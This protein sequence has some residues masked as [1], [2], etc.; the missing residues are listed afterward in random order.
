M[1]NA[2]YTCPTN[3]IPLNPPSST[4]I[5]VRPTPPPPKDHLLWSICN[6]LY[7]NFCCLGFLALI[8]SV[9]TRDQNV[10]GNVKAAHLYSHK[11]K[12][13]NILASG[14]NV[15]IPLLIIVLIVTG[16]VHLSNVKGS[17]D[18]FGSNH[19]GIAGYYAMQALKQDMIG[20]SYTNTSPLVV[21]TRA[22]DCTLGTNPISV[23][24]P[25]ND[26]DSFVLD[27]ATS[28]VALGKVELHH[29]SGDT[30]PEGWGCDSHGKLS[31]DPGK[32]LSGGGLLPI[33][34]CE[35]TG[36]YK[37]YGLGMMV[38][39]FCGILAGSQYSKHIRTW[40]VTDRVAN[41]GQCFVAINPENFTPGFKD[42]M[43][44]LLTLHRDLEPAEPG[45]PVMVPGDPERINIKRC[46]E[47][48]GLSYHINVINH[49]VG[50]TV[51]PKAALIQSSTHV[52]GHI[53]DLYI[54]KG[55]ELSDLVLQDLTISD[56]FLIIAKINFPS[57]D[58]PKQTKEM[59]YH[60]KSLLDP[61]VFNECL[62][63]S[64][65]VNVVPS[66]VDDAVALYNLTLTNTINH[67]APL[68]A[69]IIKIICSAPWS[70]DELRALK[71]TGRKLEC[72]WKRS[73]L[74][75]HK[76]MWK[77]HLLDYR[78]ALNSAGSN[79]YSSII[80]EGQGNPRVL[81]GAVT[82]VLD[83]DNFASKL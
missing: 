47:L 27:M 75:V 79:Y 7:M 48:G 68:K 78:L 25:A 67:I 74:V 28:A 39:V 20:M 69:R 76:E 14:W 17:Y 52:H 19:Y 22:R 43:S 32:V 70:N 10:L 56:H 44:D 26:G 71:T 59:T 61:V 21:P 64:P 24:A 6:T 8:Y 57:F 30:I 13:Y 63:S 29:R 83:C 15:I 35:A 23:A 45:T 33:G 37:G 11:A 82:S 65:L 1:D 46:K 16:I 51:N 36:G 9:K 3:S 73:G 49:M 40:K 41:L 50:A 42:R 31:T 5:N 72:Q 53:L 4:V 12:W 55:R 81:C 54:C 80:T 34:G 66:N 62:A 77:K 18:F 60:T 2:T 58:Q 38:E